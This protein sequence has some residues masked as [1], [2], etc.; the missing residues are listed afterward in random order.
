MTRTVVVTG[1]S[2]GVGRACVRAFAEDGAD[3]ALLARDRQGLDAAAREVTE[4]GRRARVL[5][6]TS[7]T[8]QRWRQRR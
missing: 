2:S 1:A 6:V 3:V 8:Q 7:P 5:Q 4:R